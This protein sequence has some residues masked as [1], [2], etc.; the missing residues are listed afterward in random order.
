MNKLLTLGYCEGAG[1]WFRQCAASMSRIPL[2]F[3][4]SGNKL[5][6]LDIDENTIIMFGGGEDIPVHY[7]DKSLQTFPVESMRDRFE[8]AVFEHAVERGAKLLGI[9]RGA[10][11][12]TALAGGKLWQDVNNH[13]STHLITVDKEK[14]PTELIPLI[15]TYTTSSH[16][17]MCRVDTI[18]FPVDLI[19]WSK[20][21]TKFTYGSV[22][23]HNPLSYKE[24]EIWYVPMIKAL[25]FQ[26]HPEYEMIDGEYATFSRYLAQHYFGN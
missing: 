13:H 5:E 19:G 3:L 15:P 26:G 12:I 14:V 2:S 22:T 10:Q 16:H 11:M 6:D 24:P 1:P 7:Y 9:C 20:E 18:P 17:Q 4:E 25:C 23:A 21:A 8:K